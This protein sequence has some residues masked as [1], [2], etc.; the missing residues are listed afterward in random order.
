[1]KK[2]MFLYPYIAPLI[3]TPL[4]FFLWQRTYGN[5][6]KLTLI[7]WLIPI[8]WAYIVPGVGTNICKVW[9]F[10]TQFKLGKF[11]PHHGFVFGSFTAFLAWLCHVDFTNSIG[12]IFSS[13]LI[14]ASVLG[15]WN[16]LYDIKAIEIGIIKVYNQPWADSKGSEAIAMDYAPWFFGGFGAV[17]G[18]TIGVTEFLSSTTNISWAY[19]ILLFLTGLSLSIA[20]PVLGFMFYSKHKHGHTGTK[21]I[22]K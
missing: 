20:V 3:L 21:P 6:L 18:F 19:F 8:C 4:S 9:E 10:N 2:L 12:S 5:N 13:A 15:F 7:A 1:M 14:M 17:Y 22:I 16:I 11:R